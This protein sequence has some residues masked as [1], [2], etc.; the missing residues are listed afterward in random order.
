MVQTA[1]SQSSSV[2]P[3]KRVLLLNRWFHPEVTGGAE[4]S[5]YDLACALRTAGVE[6]TVFCQA[7]R[8][9][10]GW[11]TYDGFRVYR[12]PASNAPAWAWSLSHI[13]DH[14]TAVRGLRHIAREIGDQPMIA[15]TLAYTAIARKA[16]P[17]NWVTYWCPGSQ[18]Q[19][20]GR[21]PPGSVKTVRDRMW[22]AI[23]QRQ[24]ELIEHWAHDGANLC[25]AEAGHVGRDLVHRLGVDPGKV[26]VRRNGI[27][28]TRFK[29][30]PV[31]TAL[32]AELG[33]APGTPTILTVARLE[34]MKNHGFL[35]RAFARMRERAALLIVGKGGEADRLKQQAIDLGI[36]D[37][38]KFPGFRSDIT[39]FY[40]VA[41]AFVL[42]S[43][44]EPYGNVF[45]EALGC[46]L[47]TI[48][49]RP[50]AQVCVPSD[51]HVVEGE[52]GFLVDNGDETGLATHL[53]RLV[54]DTALRARLSASAAELARVRYDWTSTAREFLA[55]F[56]GDTRT[57]IR[58]P[59][60]QAMGRG[61]ASL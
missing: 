12:H 46:G 35:L 56:T 17:G 30:Q 5:L 25:V 38:V 44:Y 48:G 52:N 28:P 16:C 45:S 22:A 41:T 40:S 61:A 15:R 4:T 11:D 1:E 18:Q 3:P 49:L 37:R 29:P 42:P 39:R 32:L 58:V 26:V 55:D 31:D 50:S 57:D 24:V 36:A 7:R 47:P 20:F 59:L 54:S 51:E 8:T 14:W 10:P 53:D 43:V 27:D 2:A 21:F 33:I 19:W 6:V 9:T 60:R 13:L 23:D 34:A